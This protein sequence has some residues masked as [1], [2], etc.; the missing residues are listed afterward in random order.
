MASPST[1]HLGIACLPIPAEMN[2]R[3]EK[4]KGE[5]SARETVV[6]EV[7][8]ASLKR[9]EAKEKEGEGVPSLQKQVG[10]D[11]WEPLFFSADPSLP[12]ALSLLLFSL[13]Q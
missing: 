5:L 8:G 10:G 7:V 2:E 6:W 1:Q 9:K 3:K 4:L 11:R 12:P 13:Q